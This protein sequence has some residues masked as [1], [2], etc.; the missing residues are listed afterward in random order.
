MESSSMAPGLRAFKETQVYQTAATPARVI[1]DLDA[2]RCVGLELAA[3]RRK[4]GTIAFA[5]MPSAILIGV[6]AIATF[7]NNGPESLAFALVLAAVAAGALI[8]AIA[9]IGI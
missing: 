3:R 7:A 4:W 6:A 1:A 8:V 2:V 9:A 5:T